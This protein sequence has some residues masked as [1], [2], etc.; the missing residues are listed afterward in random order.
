MTNPLEHIFIKNTSVSLKY[1]T[2]QTGGGGTNIPTRNRQEHTIKLMSQFDRIWEQEISLREERQA[3]SLSTRKGTYIEFKSA[4][5]ADL[6]TK[7]MEDMRQNIRLLNIRTIESA[8]EGS[9]IKATVYIPEG[10]E[11]LF[12]R[13][14]QDYSEKNTIWN[15][16]KNEKLINSIED[17]EIALVE[18]LWTDNKDLIPRE[19]AKWCEVWLR[20]DE[21][22]LFDN[23]IE[24]FTKILEKLQISYK[25]NA[26]HFVERAVCLISA[27][28]ETLQELI[29]TSDQLA[30][31]RIGQEAAGFW[32]EES[33]IGQTEWVDDLLSRLNIED[34]HVKVCILDSGINNGHRLIA[35]LVS[36]EDCLSVNPEWGTDDVSQIAGPRGHGTLMAGIVG[37]DS[38]QKSLEANDGVLLT[39]KICSVKILPR[40]GQ[41]KAENWGDYTEQAIYR[42]E[43]QNSDKVL[44]F[45]MAVTSNVDVDRGKPSS[46]SGIIDSISFGLNGNKRLFIISGGNVVSEEDW[47]SYPVNN[48]L[49]SVQNPAQSWNSLTIGAYTEKTIVYDPNF[50]DYY[51]I[52]SLREISPYNSTSFLWQ[53][54]WPIKPDVVFEGGNIL[55][56]DFGE[57]ETYFERHPDLEELTTSKNIQ[58]RQ[59]DTINGTSCATAKASW[60]S[61]KIAY[62]YPDIWPET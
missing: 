9:H 40:T 56:K 36:D 39:H 35:P 32:S 46:W 4:V 57:N 59:F 23:Q 38:L 22:K 1:T 7:S 33:N 44:L 8:D 52:A 45:C 41:S 48:K 27:N 43:A 20:I 29:K 60:L 14:I 6:I 49:V 47:K 24:Q 54:K 62:K 18:S 11:H 12:I 17:I 13:K 16:P 50:S 58:I 37:Y 28:Q 30:E 5:N 21:N 10:K 55:R 61:A 51:P 34:S 3:V 25:G 19:Q 31:F 53:K 15:R 26:L 42:A 2:T